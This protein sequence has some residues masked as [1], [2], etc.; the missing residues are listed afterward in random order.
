MSQEIG[1]HAGAEIGLRLSVG[2]SFPYKWQIYEYDEANVAR[3]LA[4]GSDGQGIGT[5]VASA[6]TVT[7]GAL[8]KLV[9]SVAVVGNDDPIEVDVAGQVLVGGSVVG[10]VKGA[11]RIKKPVT[12][13]FV[14]VWLRGKP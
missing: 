3:P 4:N 10:E 6:S 11:L 2:G 5:T 9:W 13:C 8:R 12:N 1:V 7:N 14:H